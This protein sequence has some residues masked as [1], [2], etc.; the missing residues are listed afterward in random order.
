MG[1]YGFTTVIILD[2]LPRWKWAA[3]ALNAIVFLSSFGLFG[4]DWQNEKENVAANSRGEDK[5][6]DYESCPTCEGIGMIDHPTG[7]FP[8]PDCDG[9]G[10][11]EHE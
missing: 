1:T 2:F 3:N 6:S 11:F 10:Y 9:K 7:A 4:E 8:C 5:M